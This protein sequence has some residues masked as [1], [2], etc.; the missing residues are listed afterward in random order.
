MK[1]PNGESKL[2]FLQYVNSASEPWWQAQVPNGAV[3]LKNQRK[4]PKAALAVAK[5]AAVAVTLAPALSIPVPVIANGVAT[6]NGEP[7][8]IPAV[9]VSNGKNPIFIARAKKAWVTI[10][11]KQAAAKALLA[12]GMVSTVA[13]TTETP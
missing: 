5:V 11:A 3:V 6:A 10:R 2:R 8:T 1:Y 9:V 12:T 7:Q 4:K 13:T